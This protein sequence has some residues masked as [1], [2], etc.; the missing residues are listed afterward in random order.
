MNRLIVVLCVLTSVA[1]GADQAPPP[2]REE[3]VSTCKQRL[4][5]ANG[6]IE[7]ADDVT[8]EREDG[9]WTVR[10]TTVKPRGDFHC[11]TVAESGTIL[12]A[13]LTTY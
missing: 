10:G 4:V 12:S 5:K 1:C 8:A 13:S 9:L 7:F 6:S 3:V 2:S 11:T